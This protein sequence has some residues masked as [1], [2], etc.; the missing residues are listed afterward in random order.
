MG[1]RLWHYNYFTE[2]ISQSDIKDGSSGG[3]GTDIKAGINFDRQDADSESTTV[4]N[5]NTV[6]YGSSSTFRAGEFA[7]AGLS[8]ISVE[9]ANEKCRIGGAII[10]QVR[11]Q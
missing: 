1:A 9:Q 8:L 4:V 11:T 2:S 7:T 10:P 5:G 3:S 6:T